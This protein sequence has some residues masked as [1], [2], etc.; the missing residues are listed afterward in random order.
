MGKDEG[1]KERE[2]RSE[3]SKGSPRE[4]WGDL[5]VESRCGQ[6]GAFYDIKTLKVSVRGIGGL[7]AEGSQ[8]MCSLHGQQSGESLLLRAAGGTARN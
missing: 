2:G 4:G 5:K 6:N 3:Q 8:K 7:I 1:Q